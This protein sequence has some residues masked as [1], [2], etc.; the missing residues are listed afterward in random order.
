MRREPARRGLAVVGMACRFPG[1]PDLAAYWRLLGSGADALRAVPPERW[2]IGAFYDPDPAAP[3]KMNCR[4]GGFVDGIDLFDADFFAISPREAAQL[5]P[6][7]RMVLETGWEALEDA[8]IPPERLAG[9]ATGVFV[10]TLSGE[11][12]YE[13]FAR[14]PGA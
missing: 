5:D 1:A 3:G 14:R 2:D 4:T 9:S 10:A 7:Q 6:R 11:Y 8:G 12:E 13:P